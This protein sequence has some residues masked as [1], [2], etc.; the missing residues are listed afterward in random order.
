MH[1]LWRVCEKMMEERYRLQAALHTIDQNTHR[2]IHG[3]GVY[4]LRDLSQISLFVQLRVVSCV[5]YITP[6]GSVS[7]DKRTM[8]S[9][10]TSIDRSS[11]V[12]TDETNLAKRGERGP[13]WMSFTRICLVLDL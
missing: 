1:F 6:A 12:H 5:C 4:T 13:G 11:W 7:C 2:R 8:K 10:V 3:W 9:V